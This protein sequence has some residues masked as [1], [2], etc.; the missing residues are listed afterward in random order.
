[1]PDPEAG[2]GLGLWG[3]H[4]LRPHPV[5]LC[6]VFLEGQTRTGNADPGVVPAAFC[7]SAEVVFSVSADQKKL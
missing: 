6:G 5:L 4:G 2:P 1:M 7:V 3:N